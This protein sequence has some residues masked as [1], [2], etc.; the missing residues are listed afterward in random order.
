MNG[1]SQCEDDDSVEFL[2]VSVPGKVAGILRQ[3]LRFR[4]YRVEDFWDP[5]GGVFLGGEIS[6]LPSPVINLS[7]LLS[8]V[9]WSWLWLL[10]IWCVASWWR[11]VNRLSR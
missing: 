2:R 3:S 11:C 9:S 6:E 4:T 1:S 7:A 10:R 5:P 8:T